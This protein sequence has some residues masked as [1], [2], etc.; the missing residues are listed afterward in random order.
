MLS[1]SRPCGRPP[2]GQRFR[3][4]VCQ[5]ERVW[6]GEC[7]LAVREGRFAHGRGVDTAQHFS[8][9]HSGT[10]DVL[11]QKSASPR[12]GHLG[13]RGGG[14]DLDG[15]DEPADSGMKMSARSFRADICF[16]TTPNRCGG[17]EVPRRHCGA[18]CTADRLTNAAY[19]DARQRQL[20][21][22]IVGLGSLATLLDMD[23]PAIEQ[24]LA[25][26]FEGRDKLDCRQRAGVAHGHRLGKGQHGAPDRVAHAAAPTRS[27]TV[28]SSKAMPPRGLAR[29]MAAQR[30]VRGIRSLRRR[31]WPRRSGCATCQPDAVR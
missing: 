31:R 11:M 27:A 16:M 22:N 12:H 8:K 30:F 19:T 1:A 2:T 21:K 18:W 7:Q 9:Q 15:R 24:L 14:V 28:F 17:I 25:D 13:A 26:Q 20:F 4:Q 5:C 23:V 10:A 29:F 6:L 3:R